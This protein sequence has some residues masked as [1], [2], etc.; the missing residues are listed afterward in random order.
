MIKSKCI[1]CGREMQFN[2]PL[3]KMDI[4]SDA[5]T[6]ENRRRQLAST[7]E[8]PSM[9]PL[10]AKDI[11]DDGFIA[12]TKAIVSRASHD[13][14]H[15]KPGTQ[16][17]IQAENFFESEYFTALTGLDGHAI[18]RDLRDVSKSRK[19]ETRGRKPKT[20][21][22]QCIETGT[23]YDSIKEAAKVNNCHPSLIRDVCAKNGR[24][25]RA[26][27]MHWRYVEDKH[28]NE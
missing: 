22:V 19:P 10:E 16:V 27:G 26:A 11:T 4:C 2:N 28:E 14:T 6:R 1:I 23:V 17:R 13:V 9:L 5:C 20:R 24:R 18:L 12:I 7:E 15:F 25:N 3:V 21:A 8:G